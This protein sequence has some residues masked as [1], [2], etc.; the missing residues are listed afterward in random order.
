MLLLKLITDI[1][2]DS[3]HIL[4]FIVFC[5]GETSSLEVT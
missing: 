4:V 1:L 5:F 2:P 3:D